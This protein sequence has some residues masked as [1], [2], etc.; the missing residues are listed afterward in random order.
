MTPHFKRGMTTAA[1]QSLRISDDK[2]ERL[3]RLVIGVETMAVDNF[4]KRGS[5]LSSPA[6]LY[7]Y[8][9]CSS[10][11]T[12]IWIWVKEKWGRLEQVAVGGAGLL[13]G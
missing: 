2:K 8:R 11:R 3:S 7:G 10:F 1:F 12:A 6:A 4:R 5:R 9:F 13:T